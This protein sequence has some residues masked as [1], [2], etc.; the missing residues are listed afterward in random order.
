MSPVQNAFASEEHCASE[1][2]LDGVVDIGEPAANVMFE[3]SEQ[4]W[5]H[6]VALVVFDLKAARFEN[7][8]LIACSAN[9]VGDLVEIADLGRHFF[10]TNLV[11]FH[12]RHPGPSSLATRTRQSRGGHPNL[13]G[14]IRR[15]CACMQLFGGRDELR[16]TISNAVV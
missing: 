10:Q 12:Q 2:L 13:C 14:I 5:L 6:V 7:L 4:E 16:L 11:A 8:N 1:S 15:T 3:V 9:C